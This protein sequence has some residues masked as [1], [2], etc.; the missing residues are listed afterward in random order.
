M[1]VEQIYEQTIRALPAGDQIRLASLIMWQFAGTGNL[2]YSE[3]WTD[4]D[5]REF[6]AAGQELIERRLRHEEDED[7]DGG[8]R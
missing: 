7:E 8:A 2:D 3:E 6:A 5:L 4:D 1:T